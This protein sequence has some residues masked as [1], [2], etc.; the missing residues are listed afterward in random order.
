[1][2]GRVTTRRDQP[3]AHETHDGEQQAGATPIRECSERARVT[4]LGTLRTVTVQPRGGVPALEAEICDG[5]GTI[6]IVWLGRRHIAGIEPG[7]VIRA[8]GL[9]VDQDG[10]K[11]M[12]NP[13]YEL[14][15][16]HQ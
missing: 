11:V 8:Y 12:F 3:E 7:R 16:E 13:R 2:L 1:M 5:S 9:I 4:V 10:K 15:R 6:D 14:R